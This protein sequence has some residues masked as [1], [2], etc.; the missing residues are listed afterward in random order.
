M[1]RVGHYLRISRVDR[2]PRLQEH[3]TLAFIGRRGWH[4][5]DTFLDHAVGGSH[6]KRPEFDRML[7]KNG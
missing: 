6:E 7:L 2:N 3:D 4:L 5:V 1:R